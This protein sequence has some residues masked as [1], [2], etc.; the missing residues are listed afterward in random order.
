MAIR[1]AVE[2]QI[3]Q[4]R[5]RVAMDIGRSLYDITAENELTQQTSTPVVSSFSAPATSEALPE[6]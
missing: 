6:D 2:T 1:P 3:T 4:L 5:T